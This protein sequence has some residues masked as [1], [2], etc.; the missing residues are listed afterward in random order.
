VVNGQPTHTK[1]YVWLRQGIPAYGYVGS[2][3]YSSNGFFTNR[4]AISTS[5]EIASYA[6]YCQL[7]GDAVSC[8]NVTTD[9]IKFRREKIDTPVP[10]TNSNYHL[11]DTLEVS[12]LDAKGEMHARSGLNWGQRDGRNKNQAY[13]PVNGALRTANFF[14]PKGIVFTV[15]TDDNVSF[16][17]VVAQDNDKALETPQ[18]NAI[19]GAYFR[20]RLNLQDG[21]YVTKN[22]LLAYGRTSVLFKKLNDEL[23]FMDFSKTMP[24]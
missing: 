1:L 9:K 21:A 10:S 17:L 16:E 6:Y 18:S 5:A 2:P 23:Y 15:I 20:R 12:L 14:P 11:S 19:L 13:I 24:H 22:D 4:E 7:L 8:L 3:N